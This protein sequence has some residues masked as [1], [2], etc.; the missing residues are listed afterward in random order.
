[1]PVPDP[2]P[3]AI[4]TALGVEDVR[5]IAPVTGGTDTAIWRVEAGGSVHALRLFRAEQTET[6]RRELLA[7]RAAVE[8]GLPVPSVEA[9]ATWQDRPA[10]LLSWCEGRPLADELKARPWRVWSLGAAFGR[11]QAQ[12]HSVRAPEAMLREPDRWITW[13]GPVDAALRERLEAASPR[14][15]ALLHFDYHPFNILAGKAGPTAVL[16]WANAQAGDPRADFARTASLLRLAAAAVGSPERF[17][18]AFLRLFAR[19]WR[20]GYGQV[21][22]PL[23]DMAPFYAWAGSVLVQDLT[24]KVGR[25]GIWLQ[26]RHLDAMRRWSVEWRQR[27]GLS[28]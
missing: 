26:A 11:L 13:A 5:A 16:D 19:A 14:S 7:M 24:P 18:S 1:M 15:D 2:D 4:L 21:S 25:P 20:S 9:E 3:N 22:R 23:S 28:G 17:F 12:I 27:A 10:L 8:S 6:C